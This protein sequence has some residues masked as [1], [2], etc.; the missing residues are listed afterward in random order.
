MIVKQLTDMSDILKL[1]P[2]EV[3]LRAKEKTDV[4][5]K[6]V[7][8][9]IQH[10]LSNPY[11]GIWGVFDDDKMLGYVSAYANIVGSTREVYIWRI[12]HDPHHN[13]VMPVLHNV[14]KEFG[15]MTKAKKARIEVTRGMKALE[16]K[17]GWK[18]KSVIMELEV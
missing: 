17:W 1:V 14:L 12:W 10:Q 9:F 2:I 13:E 7:L 3:A 11:F 15:K 5:I 16:R 6:D 4:P 18:P 8:T